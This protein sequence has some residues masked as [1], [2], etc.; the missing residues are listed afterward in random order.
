MRNIVL[1]GNSVV[2]SS[3]GATLTRAGLRVVQLDPGQPDSAERLRAG[4]PRIVIF[5]RAF[6]PA[7]FAF[8]LLTENSDVLLIGIDLD[9][10]SML[11]LSGQQ[12]RLLTTE[13][14]LG[15]INKGGDS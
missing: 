13:D 5:D 4:C 14:L 6:A 10:D 9:R 2:I 8:R 11:V 15:L 7:E 3:I 12:P 1:W